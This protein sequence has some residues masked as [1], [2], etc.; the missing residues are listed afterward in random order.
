LELSP[1]NGGFG[2][3]L[4]LTADYPMGGYRYES[5]DWVHSCFTEGC[6]APSIETACSIVARFYERAAA[7]SIKKTEMGHLTFLAGAEALLD[8]T[9]AK[10]LNGLGIRAPELKDTFVTSAFDYIVMDEDETVKSNYCDMVIANRV[11][12]RLLGK[13]E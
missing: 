7:L 13:R 5:G 9:V 11:A 2:L 3:S 6:E 12:D 10:S 1:W 4:R 8:L